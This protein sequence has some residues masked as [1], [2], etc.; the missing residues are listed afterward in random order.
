M[1]AF[2]CLLLTATALVAMIQMATAGTEADTQ[3]S[4]LMSAESEAEG[5]EGF[6]QAVEDAE[7]VR[8][9]INFQR[10]SLTLAAG[11]GGHHHRR[12]GRFGDHYGANYVG[13]YRN[14]GF[15]GSYDPGFGG[16][17]LGIPYFGH[18]GRF[19]HHHDFGFG[20]P[21]YG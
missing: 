11:R 6:E 10:D 9:Q 15:G 12:G 18:R 19:G 14:Y 5:A 13:N 21:N 17:F 7:R 16:G 8:R 20:S 4:S 3:Q 1:R 2:I